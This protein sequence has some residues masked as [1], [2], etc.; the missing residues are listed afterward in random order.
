MTNIF[1]ALFVSR[2]NSLNSSLSFVRF[3][4]LAAARAFQTSGKKS[5][6]PLLSSVNSTIRKITRL[7]AS[8]LNKSF[9]NLIIKIHKKFRQDK[10]AWIPFKL[11]HKLQTYVHRII[12]GILLFIQNPVT[13][14]GHAQ[15][16][17]PAMMTMS[18]CSVAQTLWHLGS[19]CSSPKRN[20]E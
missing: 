7:T 17:F 20:Q 12:H 2:I 18:S 16:L 8:A 15:L 5:F 14:G 1:P 19:A 9:I 10:A 11:F 13:S 4:W 6:V 3:I